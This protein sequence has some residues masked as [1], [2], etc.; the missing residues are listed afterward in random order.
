LMT[1]LDQIGPREKKGKLLLQGGGKKEARLPFA[2]WLNAKG[3]GV[4]KTQNHE[5]RF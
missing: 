5:K 2:R 3:V 4:L 1:F